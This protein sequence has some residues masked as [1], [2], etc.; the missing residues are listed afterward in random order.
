MRLLQEFKFKGGF[1]VGLRS[2][3]WSF[4]DSK[5]NSIGLTLYGLGGNFLLPA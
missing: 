3:S 4:K 1:R 2:F 5:T